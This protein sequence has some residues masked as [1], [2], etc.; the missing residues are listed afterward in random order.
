MNFTSTE[1][2]FILIM[3]LI[4]LQ[5][6]IYIDKNGHKIVMRNMI[7][8]PKTCYC[9]ILNERLHIYYKVKMLGDEYIVITDSSYIT[10]LILKNAMIEN[11]YNIKNNKNYSS[12]FSNF[13]L[14]QILPSTIKETKKVESDKNGMFW[15]TKAGKGIYHDKIFI[16]DNKIYGITSEKKETEL[17]IDSVFDFYVLID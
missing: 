16:R 8:V 9:A 6:I 11:F 14:F 13:K 2:L 10:P 17:N 12:A 1:I 5:F 15:A 3:L 7:N 4:T